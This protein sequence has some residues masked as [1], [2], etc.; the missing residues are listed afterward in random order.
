MKDQKNVWDVR[1]AGLGLM[2]NVPG[3]MKPL[4]FVEATAVAPE[5]L[6]QYV[7]EFTKILKQ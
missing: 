3:D 5:V 6:P 1:K 2:M 4:P 7:D